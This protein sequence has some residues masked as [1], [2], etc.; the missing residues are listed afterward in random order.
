MSEDSFAERLIAQ[1]DHDWYN[2]LKSGKIGPPPSIQ[3]VVSQYPKEK[4]GFVDFIIDLARLHPDGAGPNSNERRESADPLL[5]GQ[6]RLLEQ[7]AEGGF[8][9]IWKARDQELERDVAVKILKE[10]HLSDPK[11]K[12]YFLTEAKINSILQH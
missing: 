11:R 2:Y 9:T 5:L 3:E 8:A 10:E 1:Y 7:I 6:Y 4:P 12:A